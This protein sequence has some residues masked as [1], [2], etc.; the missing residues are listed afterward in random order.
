MGDLPRGRGRAAVGAAQNVEGSDGSLA[1]SYYIGEFG[2]IRDVLPGPHD[3][4]WCLTNNTDG[5]G[6]PTPGYDKIYQVR[7]EPV[8]VATSAPRN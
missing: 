7:L 8:A 4:V 5:R 1:V 6:T 2:R 3:T